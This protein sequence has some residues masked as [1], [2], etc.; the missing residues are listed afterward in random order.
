[1]VERVRASID[2]DMPELSEYRN[3]WHGQTALI[4]GGGP[5]IADDI[6]TIR[7]LAKKGGKIWAVN[8]THDYLCKKAL[9]PWG[10]C[11]LDPKPRV[12]DYIAKPRKK[13]LYFIA[14]Q[15]DP[16]VFAKFPDAI[17]WHAGVSYYKQFWPI[18]ILRAESKKPFSVIPGPTTV[19]LRS[20]ILLYELGFR[21]FHLFGMDSSMENNKLHAYPKDKMDGVGEKWVRLTCRDGHQ[22]FYTNAHMA[23]QAMD[24]DQLTDDL[25]ER[26]VKRQI[27]PVDITVHGRGLLP[28]MAA[29]MGLHADEEMNAR[30]RRQTYR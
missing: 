26:M 18:P 14:S 21:K 30:W 22:D 24:F 19:G 15:C 7:K 20:I 5:S 2:Y 1:M 16:A 10:A 3:K 25:A 23:K 27:E 6:K 4:C 9:Q 8:K 17:L 28:S 13:T 11:L 29:R 12:A